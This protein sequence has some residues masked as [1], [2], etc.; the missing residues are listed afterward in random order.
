MSERGKYTG[1]RPKPKMNPNT[2][3][4]VS[5]RMAGFRRR[6]FI[7]ECTLIWG[8]TLAEIAQKM[9]EEGIVNPSTGE[10]WGDATL[11]RDMA[12]LR[13]EWQTNARANFDQLVE[14]QLAKIRSAQARAWEEGKLDQ[15]AKFIDQEIKITGTG[16]ADRRNPQDPEDAGDGW[17]VSEALD[18]IAARLEER[19]QLIDGDSNIVE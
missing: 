16:T 1:K 8:L 11:R 5:S 4:M 17:S 13:E 14:V 12:M 19:K 2:N 3:S 18:R 7:A 10:P 9:A 6:A 15:Y